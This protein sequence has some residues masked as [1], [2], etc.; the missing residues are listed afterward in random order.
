MKIID[1]V[2]AL[3]DGEERLDIGALNAR[4]HQ[5]FALVKDCAGVKGCVDEHPFHQIWIRF[6]IKVVAPNQR[7]MC[8]GENRILITVINTIAARRLAVTARKQFLL[9]LE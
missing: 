1:A 9:L 3:S 6:G 5:V 2:G 4:D 8:G 7:C